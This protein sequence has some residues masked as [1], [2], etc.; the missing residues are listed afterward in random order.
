VKVE[1]YLAVIL[2]AALLALPLIWMPLII[3]TI[4]WIGAGAWL[5]IHSV[6]RGPVADA[7]FMVTWPIWMALEG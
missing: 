5:V 2:W 1:H 6:S 4:P 3:I 7:C